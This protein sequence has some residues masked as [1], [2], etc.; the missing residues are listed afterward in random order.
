[1]ARLSTYFLPTVDARVG[2]TQRSIPNR[3]PV[4]TLMVLSSMHAQYGRDWMDGWMDIGM[5]AV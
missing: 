5:E 2:P 4:A 3:R 1:M